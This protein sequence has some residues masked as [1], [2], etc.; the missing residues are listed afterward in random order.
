MSRISWHP[1]FV[2]AIEHELED[3]RNDLSFESEHQ[4]TTE[5][6]KIDVLIIKKKKNVVIK[7]NIAQIFQ[8]C[9]VV[10]YKSP[11]DRA[12]IEAY[13]KTQCYARFYA[14]LNKVDINE[15]SV[16]VVSTGHPRKLLTFL[17]N[18]YSVKSMQQGIYLVE[19]DTCPTQVL[20]SEELSEQ[21]NFWLTGL[22]SDLTTEQLAR[23]F[24]A[25][26][27]K[28]KIDA[29]V[30]AIGE[31]NAEMLEELHMRRKKGVILTEKLDAYFYEKY[32]ATYIAIGEAQ[33]EARGETKGKI[34][35]L[36]KILRARFRRVP[37]E[38]EKVIRQMTDPIALDSWAVHAATCS[39]LDEFVQ[40][41][42]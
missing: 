13:H 15:M 18:Q 26:V 17:R 24:T 8:T 29:Y 11:K 14:S 27:G 40:A 22:R 1:A 12:T 4:L 5:P 6:L 20:V 30:Y 10:E 36:L 39:S 42:K 21:D 33:G 19:G 16:T 23:V 25:A 7:K 28:S 41:L 38:T 34:E 31:A 37:A 9:N 3:H 2:Q 35:T 32:G